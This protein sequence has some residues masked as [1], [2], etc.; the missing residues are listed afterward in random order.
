M[1]F[2]KPGH[3]CIFQKLTGHRDTFKKT[4]TI[5]EN[6]D[7]WSAYMIIG[8]S[9]MLDSILRRIYI[10]KFLTGNGLGQKFNSHHPSLAKL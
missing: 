8:I 10:V 5:P 4:G 3:L 6:R 1:S 2:K 7:V 9:I